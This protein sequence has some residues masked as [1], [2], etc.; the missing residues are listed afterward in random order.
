VTP[1]RCQRPIPFEALVDYWLDP[2]PPDEPSDLEEHLFE[3]ADCS[4]GLE[5][6]ASLGEGVR[7]LGKEGRLSGGLGPSL[8][9]RLE[10]DGRVI[11]RYRAAAGGHIHCTAGADDD[12]VVLELAADLADVERVDLLHLAEDG[13]LLQRVPELPVIG[14]REIVFASPGDLIRSLPTS[15][16]FVRLMAVEPE[17]E[18]LVGEYTLHHTAYRP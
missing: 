17:G 15:V 3:C 7:R 9:E 2:R 5:A 10:Q 8:L 12:L 6:V 16:M 11:R 4:A 13:T 18:R 14:G 1:R